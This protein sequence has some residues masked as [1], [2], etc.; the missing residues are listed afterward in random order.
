MSNAKSSASDFDFLIGSWHVHH[1]RL[2]ERLVGSSEWVA[3]EGTTKAQK[4]LGGMGNMDDNVLHLPEG[5]YRAVSLRTFNPE[6]ARW[7]I[8]WLD[9][10]SPD[11]LDVPV[12]GGFADGI[13]LFFADDVLNDTP[14][15]VRFRW[16]IPADGNPLW[17]QAFSADAGTTWETNWT[18]VFR[19][20]AG[21]D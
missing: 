17:E 1:R 16:S 18:M 5:T 19:R 3:F 14:I 10:R 6:T 2:R 13:G 8:W 20:M 21:I 11:R 12:V 9:G 4:I 15:R 7:S